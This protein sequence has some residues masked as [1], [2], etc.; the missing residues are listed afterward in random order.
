MP[1]HD[2]NFDV[3]NDMFCLNYDCNSNNFSVFLILV[4]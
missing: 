2:G 4:L 1:A 3:H